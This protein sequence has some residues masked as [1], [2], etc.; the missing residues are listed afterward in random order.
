M[1]DYYLYERTLRDLDDQISYKQSELDRVKAIP[2]NAI[3]KNT[4]IQ[5]L[6]EDLTE[7][8]NKRCFYSQFL[9]DMLMKRCIGGTCCSGGCFRYC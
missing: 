6:S 1:V 5:S 2:E 3:V 7:L 8:R 4:V 9:A